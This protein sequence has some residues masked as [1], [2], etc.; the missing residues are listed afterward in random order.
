MQF[1]SKRNDVLLVNGVVEKHHRTAQAAAQE[2]QNL[3]GLHKAGVRVP[4]LITVQ[5]NILHIEYIPG[6]TIPD[7]LEQLEAH[8]NSDTRKKA[9]NKIVEWLQSFY[10]ATGAARGDINGRN[11]LFDG[12]SIWGVD[13]EE[14]LTGVC[15]P[16]IDIGRLMAFVQTYTPQGTPIKRQF[17]NMLMQEAIQEFGISAVEILHHRDTE[18]QAMLTRRQ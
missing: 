13:F 7:L 4:Q 8:P 3:M 18:L 5:D 12:E 9:T 1:K 17:A 6:A 15:A 11:F 2:A 10:N 14:P 16:A